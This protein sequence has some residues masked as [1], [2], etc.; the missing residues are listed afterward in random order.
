[1]Q[2]EFGE[3]D[4]WRVIVTAIPEEP[5]VFFA[6]FGAGNHLMRS[7]KTILPADIGLSRN[8]SARFFVLSKSIASGVMTCQ[9][10]VS[11]SAWRSRP[12][13]VRPLE[14]LERLRK[15]GQ[16]HANVVHANPT[17][18]LLRFAMKICG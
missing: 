14:S 2:C 15:C 7:S 5:R 18:F 10:G 8:R 1:M 9:T 17:A 12:R 3:T 11:G 6:D 16:K 13:R 4:H